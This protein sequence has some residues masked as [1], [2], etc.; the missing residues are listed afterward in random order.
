MNQTNT[1]LLIGCILVIL[2]CFQEWISTKKQTEAFSTSVEDVGLARFASVAYPHLLDYYDYLAVPTKSYELMGHKTDDGKIRQYF[3]ELQDEFFKKALTACLYTPTNGDAYMI[4]QLLGSQ[5]LSHT[6]KKDKKE[7]LKERI[8]N[9]IE[10]C[11]NDALTTD[12]DSNALFSVTDIILK[13]VREVGIDKKTLLVNSKVIVHRIGKAYGA[14]IEATTYH[15]NIQGIVQS[16]LLDFT[17]QGFVFEDRL[18]GEAI[19][20]NV[21]TND[22]MMY[23]D[24]GGP[25]S[26]IMQGSDHEQSTMCRY[27][28]DLQ[29]YRGITSEV[30]KEYNCS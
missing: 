28:T 24:I 4:T 10:R 15:A 25:S 13:D 22:H 3:V 6:M 19:P 16:L 5:N 17:L 21:V 29:K 30:L 23:S 2:F 8:A 9:S 1:L 18:F 12:T 27:L 26:I 14:S 11:L 20:A 7:N